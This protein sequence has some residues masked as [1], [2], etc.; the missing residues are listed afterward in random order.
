MLTQPQQDVIQEL[1]I[2]GVARNRRDAYEAGYAALLRN[3]VQRVDGS[4]GGI[5]STPMNLPELL[6]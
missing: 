6:K 3:A 1:L 5:H 4:G 2:R